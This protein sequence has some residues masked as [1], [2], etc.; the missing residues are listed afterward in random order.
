VRGQF[1]HPRVGRYLLGQRLAVDEGLHLGGRYAEAVRRRLLAERLPGEEVL[2][3]VATRSISGITIGSSSR[4]APTATPHRVEGLGQP[5]HG[6]V[7]PFK[8]EL[9]RSFD[10]RTIG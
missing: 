5:V 4:S 8:Y 9:S 2:S 10:N 3:F 6:Q 1:S 7:E